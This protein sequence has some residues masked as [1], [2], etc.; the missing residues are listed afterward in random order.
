MNVEARRRVSTV[1]L[2]ELEMLQCGECVVQN[3]KDEMIISFQKQVNSSIL[4]HFQCKRPKRCDVQYYLWV[5]TSMTS[6]PVAYFQI[7]M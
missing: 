5:C 1:L 3:D 7:C 2:L 4:S 6:S